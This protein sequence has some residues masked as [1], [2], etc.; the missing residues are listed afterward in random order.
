MSQT[1]KNNK[2]LRA[3]LRSPESYKDLD[4]KIAL[5]PK[6]FH[7]IALAKRKPVAQR[8]KFT[9]RIVLVTE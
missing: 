9:W 1:Q 6:Q 7:A 8:D 3:W 4:A 2:Q 5:L